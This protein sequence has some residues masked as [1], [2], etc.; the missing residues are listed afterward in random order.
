[1]PTVKSGPDSGRQ[2]LSTLEA[3]FNPSNLK[4]ITS[5]TDHGRNLNNDGEFASL[6]HLDRIELCRVF[7]QRNLCLVRD[8]R[9]G[10]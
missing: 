5:L 4:G 7:I 6:G 1:M 10:I 2:R 3:F 9:I 8:E